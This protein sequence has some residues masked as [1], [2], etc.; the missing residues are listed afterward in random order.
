MYNIATCIENSK[1]RIVRGFSF[2]SHTLEELNKSFDD[3]KNKKNIASECKFEDE[4][5]IIRNEVIHRTI[6]FQV[7]KFKFGTLK[8]KQIINFDYEQFELG[9]KGF[10][11]LLLHN[12][13]FETVY[14]AIASI[15]WI[16]D[17][18]MFFDKEKLKD[19]HNIFKRNKGIHF[20]HSYPF[21]FDFLDYFELLDIPAEYIELISIDAEA[22]IKDSESRSLPTYG[23]MFKFGEKIDDFINEAGRTEK[24]KEIYFPV[25][26][27]WKIT[28]QIP[29]RITE[30]ILIPYD[31]TKI[32][33]GKYKLILRRSTTKGRSGSDK[34]DQNLEGR[35]ITDEIEINKETY[36]LIDDYK[37]MVGSY[38]FEDDYYGESGDANQRDLLLSARSYH[39]VFSYHT[40]KNYIKDVFKYTYL[41]KL[42]ESFY[43]EV[44]YKELKMDLIDKISM[45]GR[46]NDN[47][48]KKLI[49][50]ELLPNEIEKIQLMDTRHFAI[51]NMIL[52]DI[53]PVA[54]QNLAGHRD[55]RTTF[56]YYNDLE[57]F[58]HNYTYHLAKKR[59]KKEKNKTLNNN[60]NSY[61]LPNSRALYFIPKIENGEIE[62]K[63]LEDNEWCI[64]EEDDFQPC[65]I[66]NY[67][68]SGD[69]KYYISY[70]SSSIIKSFK[71][72]NAEIESSIKVILEIIR[73]RNL[74]M[75]FESKIKAEIHKIQSCAEQN[76]D[77]LVENAF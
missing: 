6:D 50:K 75:N 69:C 33:N 64:Y 55:I 60:V 49:K 51:I 28:S 48:G 1:I 14:V 70:H 35:Y 59:T 26:L 46:Y 52:S 24:E 29:L 54:V 17:V 18:T 38:D 65:K 2:A 76:S 27:W 11:L 25:V 13:Y 58:V 36:D 66:V 32:V 67:N 8:K 63:K 10:V 16:L 44:L 72:N 56:R 5:W 62:A 61:E 43:L 45:Q 74:I 31:C 3:F 12:Y 21:L 7:N 34:Y 15:K 22:F 19:L 30:F 20:L 77:I 53:S 23:T 41:S 68:C 42:L 47:E 73:D 9:L 4:K 71:N 57:V 37:S 40:A 39:R